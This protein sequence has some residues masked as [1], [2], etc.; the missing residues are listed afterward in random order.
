MR[1]RPATSEAPPRRS[2]ARSRGGDLVHRGRRPGARGDRTRRPEDRG[3]A[4]AP[5]RA[6]EPAGAVLARAHGPAAPGVTLEARGPASR[7]SASG[8]IRSGVHVPGQG[9]A[10]HAG[11][12]PHH[13]PRAAGQQLGVFSAAVALVLL[14]AVANVASL[15]LVRV[16]GRWREV[17]ARDPRRHARRLVRML[18]DRE[19]RAWRARG[20]A[21]RRHRGRRGSGSLRSSRRSST[22]S[23]RRASVGGA[24]CSPVVRGARDRSWSPPIHPSALRLGDESTGAARRRPFGRRGRRRAALGAQRSWSPSSRWRCRCWPGR[25]S[26][27]TASSGSSGSMRGSI[28]APARGRGSSCRSSPI[29]GDSI[30]GRYWATALPRVRELPGVVAAGVATAVPPT[31]TTSAATTSTSWTIRWPPGGPSPPRP[32]STPDAGYFPTLGIPLLEG[33]LLARRHRRGAGGRPGQPVVGGALLP[34]GERRRAGKLYNGGCT[35]CPPCVIVGVVGDVKYQGL[36]ESAEAVYDPVTQGWPLS[37][38]LFVRTRGPPGGGD[39]GGA[40]GAPVG[41]PGRPARRRGADERSGQ[42]LDGRS[43]DA[44]GAGGRVRGGG[45]GAGG[46]RDLRDALL[47]RGH[48]AARDRGADGARCAERAGG[49][50]DRGAGDAPCRDRRVGGPRRRAWSGPAPWRPRSTA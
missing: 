2:G 37:S 9:G 30:I 31:T 18:V 26:C 12:A 46:D 6:A 11:P 20:A 24:P 17:R 36:G 4:C 19:R 13:D 50:D 23:T 34:G 27:S 49:G 40:F 10:A 43:A 16:T 35:T 48:A 25:G 45:A 7:G 32:G 1:S 38:Y 47:R 42:R 5:D 28:R 15:M 33:R 3:L 29:R 14:I 41:G 21:R 39:R 22:G 44:H 8:S